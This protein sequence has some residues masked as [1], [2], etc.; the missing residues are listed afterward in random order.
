MSRRIWSSRVAAV[1][2][3][4]VS[5]AACPNPPNPPTGSTE[6]SSGGVEATSGSSAGSTGSDGAGSNTGSDG[7]SSGVADE[8]SSTTDSTTGPSAE[9]GNGRIED[10]EQCDGVNWGG[11]TCESLGFSTG[12]LACVD[13]AFD[14]SECG[15]YPGMVLVPGGEFTM[16]SDAYPQE[17][18]VRTVDVSTFW[19]DETEVTVGAYRAC[20]DAGGCEEAVDAGACNWALPDR[21]DH[22][23]NCVSWYQAEQYCAWMGASRRLPTEAEWEKAARG[24]TPAGPTDD[25]YPWGTTPEAS[26]TYAIMDDGGP[27]CGQGTTTW[28]VGSRPMGDSPYGAKDMAGN[29]NEWVADWYGSYDPADVV[30]PTGPTKGT[31]RVARGG[32]FQSMPPSIRSTNRSWVEP[33]EWFNYF[34]FR[35]AMTPPTTTA[36]EE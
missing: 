4:T 30:D 1:A 36:N 28:P 12:S 26:C 7:G 21:D 19:I 9:C 6:D 16:G 3:G 13:C 17:Q 33:T 29:V 8:T 24:T 14:P 5:I 25:V 15:P 2:I 32:N 34:G 11:A 18:P 27:A 31:D 23:I 10:G 20:V 35:C 22:P